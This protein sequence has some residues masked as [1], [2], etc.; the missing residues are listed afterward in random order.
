MSFHEL[1]KT[2]IVLIEASDVSDSVRLS[3]RASNDE[4]KCIICHTSTEEWIRGV[5][6][7]TP[8]EVS[9]FSE[10]MD[11]IESIKSLTSKE[12]VF[13]DFDIYQILHG[14]RRT[15]QLLAAL[16]GTFLNSRKFWNVCILHGPV[17][18]SACK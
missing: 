10:E 9:T 1:P 8:V 13:L 16:S 4:R 5:Y 17:C 11:N 14:F 12:V 7:E 3:L 18:N 6:C 2:A 15:V